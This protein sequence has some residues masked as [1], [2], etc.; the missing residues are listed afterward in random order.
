M[1][2]WKSAAVFAIVAMTIMVGSASAARADCDKVDLVSLVQPVTGWAKL[3]VTHKGLLGWMSVRD[4]VPGDAYT[5]WWIYFDD[6]SLCATPGACGADSDFAGPD[7]ISVFGRLDST[8]ANEIGRTHF[9]GHVGGMEPSSGSQIWMLILGH[10]AAD[11]GDPVHL[12]RQLLTPED[13]AAGAPH[14]G[15]VAHGAHFT[16]AALAVFDVD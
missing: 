13:P 10:D 3:C 14:L 7:P 15:I 9:F 11:Y 16:P 1:D 6:P 4:L 12:A 5:V 2:N 8:V